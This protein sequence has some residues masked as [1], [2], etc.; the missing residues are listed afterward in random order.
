MMYTVNYY[1]YGKRL[2]K[3][4]ED[5]TTAFRYGVENTDTEEGFEV[6]VPLEE[7]RKLEEEIQRLK[8]QFEYIERICVENQ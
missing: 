5:Y 1:K 4:A 6:T 2:W 7:Y 3:K 8:R